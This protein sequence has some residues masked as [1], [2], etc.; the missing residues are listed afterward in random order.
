MVGTLVRVCRPDA[1]LLPVH[2]SVQ[3]VQADHFDSVQS[4]GLGTHAVAPASLVHVRNMSTTGQA[5]QVRLPLTA[6]NAQSDLSALHT[7]EPENFPAAHLTHSVEPS[8][9]W[10]RPCGQWMQWPSLLVLA[11]PALPKRPSE[12]LLHSVCASWSV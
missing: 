12:Q 11:L 2:E 3:V 6:V 5:V 10:K 1:L 9:F 4:S 7:T 8:N